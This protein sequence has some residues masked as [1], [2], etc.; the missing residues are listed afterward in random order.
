MGLDIS[1]WSQGAKD[2]AAK[3]DVNKDNYLDDQEYS[4]FNAEI[5]KSK[6]S[7]QS[8]GTSIFT[9]PIESTKPVDK[10]E[11][12]KEQKRAEEAVFR[13]LNTLIQEG[14]TR[15]D[16]ISQLDEKLGN[17]KDDPRY[18]AI[19]NAIQ[20]VLN[21][22]LETYASN[23]EIK[24]KHK[25]IEKQLENQGIKDD[26]HKDILKTLEEMAKSEVVTDDY[27]TI[28]T[29]FEEKFNAANADE[30][31]EGKKWEKTLEQV[32]N[33]IKQEYKDNKEFKGETKKAFEAYEKNVIMPRAQQ[34]VF[35]AIEKI[36]DLE[37]TSWKDVR[38]KATQI[39]K[40]NGTWDKYTDKALNHR[41]F[42]DKLSGKLNI[43]RIAC[44]NQGRENNVNA[45]KNQTKE[46]I[47]DAL[48]KDDELLELLTN[49]EL[50]K[51][52]DDGTYD[53]S[54]LSQ[55]IEDNL[56]SNYQ[57]DRHAKIDK[58]I[59]EKLRTKGALIARGLDGLT[60]KQAKKLVELCGFKV[61]GRNWAKAILHGIGAGL[62]GAVG[63]GAA[64]ASQRNDV[65]IKRGNTN[66]DATITIEGA[67]ATDFAGLPAG[68][69]V[70][71]TETGI[72]ILISVLIENPDI[73]L[74]I[75]NGAAKAALIGGLTSAIPAFLISLMND[76]G[77]IPETPVHFSE[78]SLDDYAERVKGETPK[79]APYLI[80]IATT[81]LD[82]NGN[83]D[84]KGYQDLLNK[85]AGDGGKL[86][87][88]ELIGLIQNLKK[89]ET[90][91]EKPVN[92]EPVK[93][94]K[95]ETAER[96]VYEEQ[97]IDVKVDTENMRHTGWAQLT[98]QYQCLVDKYGT[99][100][101]IR[102][103]KIVQG[104]NNNDYSTENIEKLLNLSLQGRQAMQNIEGFDYEAY[105]AALDGE[106]LGM[107]KV[108]TKIADCDRNN[109]PNLL[110]VRVAGRGGKKAPGTPAQDRTK[111]NVQVGTEYAA[112]VNDGNQ[113]VFNNQ[114]DFNTKV[115]GYET[116]YGTKA[117]KVQW[118]ETV[119]GK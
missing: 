78:T 3:F 107:T 10:Q 55:I 108:P 27:N 67:S 103:L 50:I 42:G 52:N 16:V 80:G 90:K 87:R 85:A 36:N 115:S 102:I 38:D 14:A 119:T 15:K 64:A 104:I 29:A 114:N 105:T 34:L 5:Q 30:I 6:Q 44:Q 69:I 83:W 93:E 58:K 54:V 47:L 76:T 75:P 77:E 113:E 65:L 23:K 12:E 59:S 20:D 21:L 74:K 89:P 32:M 63:S 46:D 73:L 28:G 70:N 116:Q 19:K 43:G 48:G 40:D 57:M 39:L 100:K 82:K 112:Q 88:E 49:A 72:E 94:N 13:Y 60:D 45:H 1:N 98:R 7:Q 92:E 66:V 51:Q 79:I 110:K 109:D 96:A 95:L 61:E 24:K 117:K 86:N 53:L 62:V 118:D 71:T 91:T 33:E 18:V 84:V 17:Q 26:L 31:K 8:Q 41:S 9:N 2:Y 101:T 25:D 99:N 111:Q 68:A 97:V 81:F 56:G 106:Y 37:T 11:E 22:M 4:L 35:E